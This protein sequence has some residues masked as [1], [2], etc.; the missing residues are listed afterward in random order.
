MSHIAWSR[1]GVF[2]TLLLLLPACGGGDDPPARAA[3]SEAPP[4]P[5]G[6]VLQDSWLRAAAQDPGAVE[7]LIDAPGGEGWLALFHGD[8]GR[9]TVAF[10]SGASQPG[11]ELAHLGL[12]RVAMARA[13]VLIAALPLK[14]ASDT[15]LLDYRDERADRVRSGELTPVLAALTRLDA[16]ADGAV[17]A[18]K[19]GASTEA[20]GPLRA[21][22]DARRRGS[23]EVPDGLSERHAERLR[24]V[25]ALADGVVPPLDWL[26]SN[27]DVVASLGADADSGVTFEQRWWDPAVVAGATRAHLQMAASHAV[28]AGPAGAPLLKV[29]KARLGESVSLEASTTGPQLDPRLAWF[30]APWID[31]AHLLRRWDRGGESLLARVAA[32]DPAMV[33]NGDTPTTTVDAQLRAADALA[34]A[35]ERT[36]GLDA[37]PEG[38]A[39]VRDLELGRRVSDSILRERMMDLAP[40]APAQARRLGERSL[41]MTPSGPGAAPDASYT[42]ISHRND[43]AFLVRLAHVLFLG[44]RPDMAREYVFPLVPKDPALAGVAHALGQLDAASSIGV[45]GKTS[46]R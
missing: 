21:L 35:V 2:V 19:L 22:L 34:D 14:R 12:A 36:L 40:T 45:R 16:G 7:A 11:G 25:R 9:A 39:L 38:A 28:A 6:P 20:Q 41:D 4:V 27:P 33:P 29:L 37:P 8:L 43:P 13:D 42:R 31:T 10:S 44:R 5:L 26:D 18:Q 1:A 3:Q 32:A 24:H 17:V 23:A 15:E 30:G 46:Q